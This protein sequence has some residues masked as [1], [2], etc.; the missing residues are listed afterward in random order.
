MPIAAGENLCTVE[1]F[2]QMLATHAVDFTQP[3]V[4][5]VG[6]ISAFLRVAE[7]CADVG[8]PLLPHCPYFGPGMQASL[9]LAAAVPGVRQLEWLYVRPEAW[10]AP[11][12][13]PGPGGTYLPS[14]RPGLGFDP[15]PD[16][17]S[18]FRRA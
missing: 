18:H 10:L 11:L 8:V 4:T 14:E 15:D 3:S 2:R 5:K 1:P 9:H 17:L 13:D 16:V 6:G 7:A 12:G